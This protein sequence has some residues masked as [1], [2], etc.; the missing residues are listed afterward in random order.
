MFVRS[1]TREVTQVFS[2]KLSSLFSRSYHHCLVEVTQEKLQQSLVEVTQE[3]LQQSLVEV[4][5]VFER[6]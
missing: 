5:I 3:K 2:K 4:I 1:Y 6:S